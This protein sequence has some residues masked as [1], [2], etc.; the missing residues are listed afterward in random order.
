MFGDKVILGSVECRIDAK[1]RFIVPKKLTNVEK[2][3]ELVLIEKSDHLEIW[4]LESLLAELDKIRELMLFAKSEEDYEKLKLAEYKITM[5]ISGTGNYKVDAQCRYNL[6]SNAVN[7]YELGDKLIFEGANNH[8][9]IWNEKTY[10]LVK[11]KLR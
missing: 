7:T 11:S 10:N 9:R 5:F 3:D 1:D 4:R 6:G 2:D 8:G